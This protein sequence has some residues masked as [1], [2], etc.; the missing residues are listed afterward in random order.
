MGAQHDAERRDET[1]RVPVARRPVQPPAPELG[2]DRERLGQQPRAER[3]DP[4]DSAARAR[5]RRRAPA[6]APRCARA[7]RRSP[8]APRRA[9]SCRTPGARGRA[10]RTRCSRRASTPRSREG[11]EAP[12]RRRRGGRANAPGA[13]T[14]R[15]SSA[16]RATIAAIAVSPG[17]KPPDANA[18]RR[19]S[20]RGREQKTPGQ[21]PSRGERRLGPP[22]PAP[23]CDDPHGHRPSARSGPARRS[24]RAGPPTDRLGGGRLHPAAADHVEHGPQATSRRSRKFQLA[25]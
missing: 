14:T 10:R 11:R 18:K 22:V 15:I 4:D 1:G 17:K 12:R 8:A 23:R 13:S 25:T 19:P 9:A 20:R 3:S 2:C 6:P 24:S 7:T 21:R 5:S 16:S